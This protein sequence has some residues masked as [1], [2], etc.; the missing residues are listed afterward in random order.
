MAFRKVISS[1]LCFSKIPSERDRGQI[2][3]FRDMCLAKMR[4]GRKAGLI[5]ERGS[6]FGRGY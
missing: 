5:F 3:E 6:T 2:L 4:S 1:L